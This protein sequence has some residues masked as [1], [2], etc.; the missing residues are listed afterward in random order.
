MQSMRH[1]EEGMFNTKAVSDQKAAVTYEEVV[2]LL[3]IFEFVLP[4]HSVHAD[5]LCSGRSTGPA[6]YAD[7]FR[8][9]EQVHAAFLSCLTRKQH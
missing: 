4:S 1:T 9:W 6:F 2:L 5:S 3:C 7:S 8:S